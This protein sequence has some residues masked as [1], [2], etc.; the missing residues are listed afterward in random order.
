MSK[1]D[2]RFI[3]IEKMVNQK[4][5]A[6]VTD[7]M[8]VLNVSDMTIR[9][10]LDELENSGKIIRIHGGA[11]SLTYNNQSEMAH[12]DKELIHREEKNKVAQIAASCIREGDTIFLGTGT[13]VEFMADF[14]NLSYIRVITNSLPV[15]E[16]FQLLHKN[17]ENILIG[18]NY[19]ERTGAFVG[20]ITNDSLVKLR[21]SRSFIGVNGINGGNVFTSSLEE[22][23][24]QSLAM[25]NASKRNILADYHKLG[26]EDFYR[27]YSLSDIDTLI[28]NCEAD[29]DAV[30][31][32]EAHTKVLLAPAMTEEAQDTANVK[33]AP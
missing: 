27:F 8:K 15:F 4:G 17:Y 14:I 16:R 21:F 9:R 19:R 6:M 22:G 3:A 11:Q 2:E 13:T 26:R 7:L 18:G 10:D 31:Q 24:T 5:V 28:T 33:E 12:R 20:G 32:C 29:T 30:S 25:Q 23:S 1:K